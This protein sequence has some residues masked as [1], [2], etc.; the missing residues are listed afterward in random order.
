MP[1][2]ADEPLLFRLILRHPDGRE[3][4]REVA[5]DRPYELGEELEIDGECWQVVK[6]RVTHVNKPEQVWVMTVEPC[7][8]SRGNGNA[9]T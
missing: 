3:E 9:P 8:P 2:R 4:V 7:P 5:L 1:D 6:L